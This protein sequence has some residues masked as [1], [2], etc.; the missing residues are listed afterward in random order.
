MR[1]ALAVVRGLTLACACGLLAVLGTSL[2]PAAAWAAG[3]PRVAIILFDTNSSPAR[4][5][6]TQERRA[7]LAYAGALPPDVRVGL[8]AFGDTWHSVLD[9]T[10]SR[11]R[12]AA[13]LAA[14]KPAGLTSKA[15]P[16]ALDGAVATAGRLGASSSSRLLVISDGEFLS[17]LTA[18]VPVPTDAIGWYYDRDD[19]AGN[20]RKIALVNGGHVAD[21]GHAAGLA[22]AFPA[23]HPHPHP[24]ARHRATPQAAPGFT[25]TTSLVEVLGLVF[26]A[27]F[28]LALIL[29]R[30]LRRGDRKPKLAGQLDRYGPKAAA[31][32]SPA[33]PDGEGKVAR[34]AV[35]LMSQV[36]SAR[37]GEPRLAQRL[38][39]A[40]IGRPPAEWALLGVCVC[41]GL[42]AALTVIFG[43]VLVGVVIGVLAG[44]LGMRLALSMKIS[45]RR[46]AFDEQLPNV[47]QMVA[48]SIQTGLSLAQ[49]LDTVVREDTQPAAGEFARALSETRLGVD[50]ADALDSV[51]YR[52]DSAD[53]RW[54][55]MAIRIQRETGG[56]LAEVLRNTVATMR[57]R[58]FLRR[59]VRSLSAEG[60]LSAY[61]LLALPLVVG[62]W[63]FYSNPKYMQPLYT[64]VFGV[65]MLAIALVLIVI[66]AF[67][68]RNLINVKV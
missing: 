52:L 35:G 55:V 11:A 46:S 18:A 59:Q 23:L 2:G 10:T 8:I 43:N 3:P 40:G 63:L 58:A 25:L 13:A 19:F 21:L 6:M 44:W 53:L 42:S 15:L 34:T 17:A 27:S 7:A 47:L 31:P 33:A 12:L 66:G 28:F 29:L 30:S 64:S 39:H 22:G 56:N 48:G 9:P 68:M 20:V 54:V 50:L 5:Q 60:R 14:L 4:D 37:E 16:A 26:V 67:W 61:V 62:G 1:A 41:I 65:G 38:D 32:A 57:E 45:K 49:G 36:L 51:A 24:S